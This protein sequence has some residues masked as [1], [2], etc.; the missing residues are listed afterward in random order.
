[1]K[2]TRANPLYVHATVIALGAAGILISGR[3]KAGKSHLAEALLALA[4][5]EGLDA[6][7]V[8]DDRVGLLAEGGGILAMPHPAIAGLIERRGTGILAV[9]HRAEARLLLEIALEAD[10]PA[11]PEADR[12]ERLPGLFILRFTTGEQPVAK[13]LFPLVVAALTP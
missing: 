6:L 4:E 10:G 12:V 3:S 9:S 11:D 7:L 2:G 1:M 13:R 8:G 5:A